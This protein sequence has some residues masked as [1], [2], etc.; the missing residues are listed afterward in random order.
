MDTFCSSLT[1]IQTNP[2]LLPVAPTGVT[3]PP[4][5]AGFGH[6]DRFGTIGKTAYPKRLISSSSQLSSSS[7]TRSAALQRA[8]NNPYSGEQK[9]QKHLFEKIAEWTGD[10]MEIDLTSHQD[11]D[12]RRFQ[13]TCNFIIASF[14]SS[15]MEMSRRCSAGR[16]F[17]EYGA[18]ACLN[19]ANRAS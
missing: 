1:Y 12:L 3:M 18:L 15:A 9:Y 16:S 10:P 4:R 13:A 2:T 17:H 7:H 11:K 8:R 6:R 14:R 19:L 5:T